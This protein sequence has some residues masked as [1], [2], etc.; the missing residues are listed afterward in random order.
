M[1]TKKA[2]IKV[3]G[4]RYVGIVAEV[5]G[6][7]IPFTSIKDSTSI[8]GYKHPQYTRRL[9]LE[10]K[11]GEVATS[12]PFSPIKVKEGN[13]SKW[14]IPVAA[15]YSYLNSRTERDSTRRFILRFNLEDLEKIEKALEASKVAYTL[16][17]AYKKGQGNGKAKS[18]AAP[19]KEEVLEEFTFN[20][21]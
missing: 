12:L 7:V 6:K 11:F 2:S 17:L 3:E 9:L 13:F 19:E 1:Q 5:E 8:L 15:L 21:S 18:K 10:D 16:E 14:F 20:P 4:K